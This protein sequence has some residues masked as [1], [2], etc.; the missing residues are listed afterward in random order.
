M[1]R[2]R[3]L[4]IEHACYLRGLNINPPHEYGSDWGASSV[5]SDL[6]RSSD[7]DDI[8]PGGFEKYLEPIPD[9]LPLREWSLIFANLTNLTIILAVQCCPITTTPSSQTSRKSGPWVRAKIKAALQ[10]FDIH[11][12]RSTIHR[13]VKCENHQC[14]C[15][16]KNKTCNRIQRFIMELWLEGSN[17]DKCTE[18][19]DWFRSMG[20]GRQDKG[21]ATKEHG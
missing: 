9:R 20:P 21:D 5:D 7:D 8:I 19:S 1:R 11:V 12:P 15:A 17:P 2:L 3:K 10:F 18:A 16:V 13:Q 4:D 14:F 6:E